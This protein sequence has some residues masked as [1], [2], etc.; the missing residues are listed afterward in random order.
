MKI[1]KVHS[2]FRNN[3]KQ[4]TA[5]VEEDKMEEEIS[6]SNKNNGTLSLPDNDVSFID[7]SRHLSSV[8]TNNN[9]NNNETEDDDENL[10]ELTALMGMDVPPKNNS[11]VQE[12]ECKQQIRIVSEDEEEET[13]P[14]C[15]NVSHDNMVCGPCGHAFCKPCMERV[16]N[17]DAAQQ[18]WPP[19][20]QVDIHLSAPTLGRCPIC[21][22]E[23]SL[24]D[25]TSTTALGKQQEYL[26]PRNI[27]YYHNDKNCP[28]QGQVYVPYRGKV[29]QLSFHWDWHKIKQ[30]QKPLPFF[31]VSESLSK[32]P[33]R[34][35][36][37]SGRPISRIKYFE[38][39]CHFHESSR[40]FHGRIVWWYNDRLNGSY[41]WD[42][43]L[44]FPTDYRFIS[45]GRIHMKRDYQVDESKL[46][47]DYT[48][49]QKQLC[50]YPLDGRWTIAWTTKEGDRKTGEIHVKN[51]EYMQQGW[52][53]HLNFTQDP[54][55]PRISWPKSQHYQTVVT[56]INLDTHPMGPP[57]GGAVVWKSTS[58]NFPKLEWIRQTVGPVPIPRVILFGMGQGKQ[59]YQKLNADTDDS[60]PKYCGQTLW[61]N[62][63]C[64]RLYVGSASYHFLSPT[65]SYISYQHISCRDMPPL[66]D[67][68]PMPTR[69]DFHNMDYNE[70]ERKLTAT[71]EWERD[72]GISWN[73]NV[74]WKL[75][76]YFDSQFM[77]I[78]KG[79]IQCEWSNVKRA[80]PR[81]PRQPN[82]NRPPPVPV[83]VPPTPQENQPA[84]PERNEEWVMSGYGHDQ[85]YINAAMLERYRDNT[86]EVDYKVDYKVVGQEQCERLAHEGATQRSIEFVQHLFQLA[87]DNPNSNP[88]DFLL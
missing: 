69:V 57:A 36:L 23:L 83:Y 16:L 82:P 4:R 81:P 56:G 33:D 34:W 61:G 75:T 51:N 42:I 73:D 40:T 12:E 87:A 41:E 74:K 76:M 50:H 18:R 64:K 88:I 27:N 19:A 20:S 47:K 63:F 31:N 6:D 15:L 70:E 35:R 46:P 44:G 71:I 49:E 79:G 9:N 14:V 68:T 32:N 21:R 67:R 43:V 17:A 59:L 52:S 26:Y 62:I 29:G 5:Q 45:S 86:V 10:A 25:I 78:L 1:I 2:Y 39:G 38:E 22:A 11:K 58:P 7:N 8:A 65:N 30:E 72:F 55:H 48:V 13:C 28:L 85:L 84:Q 54:N 3:L 24:F 37:E 53:F 66:D 80:R 77:I 60:I